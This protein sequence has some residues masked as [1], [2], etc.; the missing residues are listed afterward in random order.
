MNCGCDDCNGDW[1]TDDYP[2]CELC[3]DPIDYCLG[4]SLWQ[5]EQYLQQVEG[6]W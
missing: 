3:G 5:W 2:D 6:G 4:H 1:E